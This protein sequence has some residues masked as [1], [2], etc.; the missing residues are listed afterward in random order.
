M[1]VTIKIL[2]IQTIAR[3]NVYKVSIESFQDTVDNYLPLD[4]F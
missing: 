4:I 1:L 2:F 3:N